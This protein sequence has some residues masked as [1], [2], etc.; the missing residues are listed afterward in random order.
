MDFPRRPSH[1]SGSFECALADGLANSL[2]NDDHSSAGR[3][4]WITPNAAAGS[5]VHVRCTPIRASRAVRKTQRHSVRGISMA[6]RLEN[7]ARRTQWKNKSD[8][9]GKV[10]RN[11]PLG[12]RNRLRRHNLSRRRQ[13]PRNQLRPRGIGNRYVHEA[14][15]RD[16][17]R[18]P[19]SNQRCPQLLLQIHPPV[20]QRRTTAEATNLGRNYPTRPPIKLVRR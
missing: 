13:P 12:K 11:L 1:S 6:R 20:I 14:T 10:R 16:L 18:S 4:L 15:N 19:D 2:W 7:R 17:A 5:T 9:D 8:V 3:G